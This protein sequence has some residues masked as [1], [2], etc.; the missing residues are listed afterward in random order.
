MKKNI[1]SFQRDPSFYMDRAEDYIEKGDVFA[2]IDNIRRAIKSRPDVGAY[3]VRLA[4]VLAMMDLNS[5]SND[6][7]FRLL[8]CGDNLI[9]AYF[10]LTQNFMA[11]ENIE[12][13]YFYLKKTYEMQ[14]ED[15]NN[16]PENAF[17]S[18][19]EV[20]DFYDLVEQIEDYAESLKSGSHLT[21]AY[22]R[23][24]NFKN[25]IYSGTNLMRHNNYTSA[26]NMFA[27][28]PPESGS[29]TDALNNSALCCYAL[30]DYSKGLEFTGKVREIDP[31]NVFMMCNELMIYKRTRNKAKYEELHA[32]LADIDMADENE[33]FRMAMTMCELKEHERA[34]DYFDILLEESF[35]EEIMLLGGIAHYNAGDKE[36]AM[37]LAINT[38]KINEEN[39][40]AKYYA[41][42]FGRGGKRQTLAYGYQVQPKEGARRIAVLTESLS[43]SPEE[44]CTRLNSDKEFY[45]LFC[46]SVTLDNFGLVIK[47][48]ELAARSANY[49][50]IEFMKSR[51]ISTSCNSFLKKQIL[52]A[53]LRSAG[54]M[55]VHLVVN[56]IFRSLS[57]HCPKNAEGYP[58]VFKETYINVFATL[59]LM[60]RDFESKLLF[61]FKLLLK[62]AEPVAEKLKDSKALSAIL[63]LLYGDAQLF[64]NRQVLC[65]V[66]NT[67]MTAVRA[68]LKLLK[69]KI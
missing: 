7:F 39:L 1:I 53:C 35:D 55:R 9:D 59:S 60:E 13:A 24:E 62:N 23:E 65:E 42:I 10:G 67:N 56:D 5:R 46:W 54:S 63:S 30:R 21:L 28:I 6:E 57:Y 26:L 48:M 31:E 64:E 49:K 38:L 11:E 16:L 66:Y 25:V 43:L 41:E 19:D 51:L 69:I 15:L 34:A 29:Y 45:E 37:L 2:A 40:I 68:Y 58:E 33:I 17:Q 3:R 44:F 50:A 47:L 22:D 14:R 4:Q 18:E 32:E 61:A 52:C 8:A 20:D 27:V 36:S 12:T